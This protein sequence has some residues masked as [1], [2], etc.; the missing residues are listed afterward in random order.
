MAAG[1]VLT[2]SCAPTEVSPDVT[3][4]DRGLVLTSQSGPASN[5]GVH[6]LLQN[7]T[8][9][10]LTMAPPGCSD[11]QVYERNEWRLARHA[12]VCVA[13]RYLIDDGHALA[14]DF[15][16]PAAPGTYRLITGAAGPG[17]IPYTVASAP[18]VVK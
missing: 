5:G 17:D 15:S 13:A 6:A 3:W 16:V 14:F 11:I 1:I 9:G 2:T 12:E 7:N 4:A 18:V 8:G 10:R